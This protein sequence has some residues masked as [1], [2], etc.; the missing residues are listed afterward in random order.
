MAETYNVG[1]ATTSDI[2]RNSSSI[3]NFVSTLESEDGMSSRKVMRMAENKN[4]LAKYRA[5]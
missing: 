4:N 1:A 5:A 2:K 3:L